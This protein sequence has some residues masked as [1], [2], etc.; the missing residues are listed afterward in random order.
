MLLKA[1]P[2]D[3]VP[4]RS[5]RQTEA[6]NGSTC[7]TGWF[8]TK[9]RDKGSGADPANRERLFNE[10]RRLFRAGRRPLP[11]LGQRRALQRGRHA[12]GLAE[13]LVADDRNAAEGPAIPRW[14][15][16]TTPTPATDA[17]AR[18]FKRARA[19]PPV[20]HGHIPGETATGRS[21]TRSPMPRGQR[22][23]A[24][25]VGIV[26]QQEQAGYGRGR[27]YRQRKRIEGCRKQGHA[28]RGG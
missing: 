19:I 8:V 21:W 27:G 3:P 18:L 13:K 7:C 2:A 23:A 15:A 5:E 26:G 20:P 9:H 12:P 28:A 14:T 11:V 6:V 22:E 25:A 17:D 1:P 16:T 10:D 4:I 24:L